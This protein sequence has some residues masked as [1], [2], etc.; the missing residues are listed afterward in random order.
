M[1]IGQ[2]RVV[3][4]PEPAPN[5]LVKRRTPGKLKLLLASVYQEQ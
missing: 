4:L 3:I 5:R 1:E 2:S